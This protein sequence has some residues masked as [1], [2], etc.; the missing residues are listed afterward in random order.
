MDRVELFRSIGLGGG[1]GGEIALR[2]GE[3]KGDVILIVYPRVVGE[4]VCDPVAAG[5]TTNDL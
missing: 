4:G 1:S 3:R 5:K 2:Y